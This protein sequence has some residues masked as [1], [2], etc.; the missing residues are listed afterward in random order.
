L[1]N[2]TAP[3]GQV[4][5]LSDSAKNKAIRGLVIPHHGLAGGLITESIELLRQNRNDYQILVIIGPNH[6]Y[7]ESYTLTSSTKLQDT[8][9]DS[10]FIEKLK[11]MFPKTVLD[12]DIVG[13]EHAVT[14]A[15]SYFTEY[16]PKSRIIPL[17]ISP[18]FTEESL[19]TI[20]DFLSQNLP[21]NTLYVASVDFSHNLLTDESLVNNEESIKTIR[22]F[23]FPTLFKYTD[24]HMD[25]P[26]SVALVMLVMQNLKTTNW[27]TVESLHSG[28]ILNDPTIQGTSYVTGIFY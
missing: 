12:Q 11:E 14:T 2:K 7:K 28:L 10:E 25:S 17:V 20:A 13:A 16:F 1:L 27:T 15:A 5:G 3:F 22:S 6:F 21:R 26:A 4:K 18:Y 9:V 8:A 23:D 24:S 19:R